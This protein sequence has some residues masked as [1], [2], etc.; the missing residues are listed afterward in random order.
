MKNLIRNIEVSG[1]KGSA[2]A[3]NIEEEGMICLK[4]GID[5]EAILA[6]SRKLSHVLIGEYVVVGGTFRDW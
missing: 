1:H 3:S 4:L 2:R 6:A 5:E